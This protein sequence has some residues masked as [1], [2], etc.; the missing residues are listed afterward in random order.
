MAK[1]G[2][3]QWSWLQHN[4]LVDNPGPWHSRACS[5]NHKTHPNIKI[6]ALTAVHDR[7]AVPGSSIKFG[8]GAF[9]GPGRGFKLSVTFL[10]LFLFFVLWRR[11]VLY[12][13]GTNVRKVAGATR[14]TC[15]VRMSGMIAWLSCHAC[16]REDLSFPSHNLLW[17]CWQCYLGQMLVVLIIWQICLWRI[18]I[19]LATGVDR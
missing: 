18:R 8:S 19:F 9:V 16:E 2:E 3:W 12:R 7:V 11:C 15:C 1:S 4:V 17:W 6:P 10:R 13:W 14:G 5:L